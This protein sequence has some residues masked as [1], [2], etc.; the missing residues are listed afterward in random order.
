MDN[1]Y[2][3]ILLDLYRHPLNKTTLSA[4]DAHH[5]ETNPLCGDEVEI[6]IKFDKGDTVS[7]VGWAGE[8]CAISQASTSL[9]TDLMKNK[10]KTELQKI[11]NEEILRLLSLEKLNP[12]RLRCAL[13]G[14]ECL[15]KCL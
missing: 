13:L 2:T 11:S 14:L 15:K 5:K 1:L 8:G 12:T 7:A 6:F 4:F 9:L 10:S 3:E